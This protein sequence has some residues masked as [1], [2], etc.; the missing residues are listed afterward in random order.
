[1]NGERL[2]DDCYCELGTTECFKQL[3]VIEFLLNNFCQMMNIDK[4]K[5]ETN[6]RVLKDIVTRID[7]R[8]LYF[9]IYHNRM[10]PNEYKM[11]ALLIYWILKLRPFWITVRKDFSEESSRIAATINEH[12]CVYMVLTVVKSCNPVACRKITAEYVK[13]LVYSF[14][15]R[16][17]SKESIYLIF[18]ALNN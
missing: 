8:K 10:H 18:D 16:D 14:R 12:F 11:T 5:I 15:F 1:M 13:E 6:P 9:H 4:S 3:K 2:P 7:Q 17:L